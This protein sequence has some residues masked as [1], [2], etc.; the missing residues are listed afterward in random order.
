MKIWLHYLVMS[1]LLAL[2]NGL[3]AFTARAERYAAQ[4]ARQ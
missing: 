1:G 4:Q 3:L 2:V